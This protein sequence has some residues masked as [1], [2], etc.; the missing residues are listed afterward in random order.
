MCTVCLAI[1]IQANGPHPEFT[2]YIYLAICIR[3]PP[4]YL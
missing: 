4:P 3:Q 1:I 2:T